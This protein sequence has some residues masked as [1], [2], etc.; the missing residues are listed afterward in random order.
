LTAWLWS[1][2]ILYKSTNDAGQ[3]Q[4]IWNVTD[5]TFWDLKVPYFKLQNR[6]SIFLIK[7]VLSIIAASASKFYYNKIG[8]I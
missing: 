4:A 2:R 6:F 3:V 1:S 5:G 7:S 8:T